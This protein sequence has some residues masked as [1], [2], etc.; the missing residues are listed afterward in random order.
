MTYWLEFELLFIKILPSEKSCHFEIKSHQFF[1][2]FIYV[3]SCSTQALH[4]VE[5]KACFDYSNWSKHFTA[6]PK[7]KFVWNSWKCQ[8]IEKEAP[9]VY[10]L[11]I[12]Q[13]CILN[14]HDD[15][16]NKCN[17]FS[18]FG[19]YVINLSKSSKCLFVSRVEM[20][21]GDGYR[22][23]PQFP[24]FAWQTCLYFLLHHYSGLGIRTK[25]VTICS[26]TFYFG[27][28]DFVL[29]GCLV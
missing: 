17:K 22:G 29:N 4:D 18:V 9:D 15:N 24:P 20:G 16:K 3:F 8:L 26:W 6:L 11:W 25:A 7:K 23:L 19:F 12:Y 21:I 1:E 2:N 5:S 28:N 10:F 14:V 27:L 13:E